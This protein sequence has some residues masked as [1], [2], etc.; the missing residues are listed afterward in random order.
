MADTEFGE[1]NF[2][3]VKARAPQ[4]TGGSAGEIAERAMLWWTSRGHVFIMPERSMMGGWVYA[5]ERSL[6][7]ARKFVRFAR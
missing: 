6:V 7:I 4:A 3:E 2:A 1:G 5:R